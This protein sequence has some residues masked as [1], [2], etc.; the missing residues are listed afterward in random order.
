MILPIFAFAN[1]GVSLI[2]LSMESLFSPMTLGIALGLFVGKQVGVFGICWL[3]IKTGLAKIPEG[4]NWTQL[5]GVSLLCGIGFTMSLFIG[6]LAFE[7]QGLAYQ[8]SVKAG[9]LI[10][11]IMSA[12]LGGFVISRT[13]SHKTSDEVKNDKVSN[14][15]Y[16]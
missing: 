10:G 6:S 5:Y 13:T 2:G 8:A 9:V 12:L 3:A 14:V 4:S 1:A 15:N 11:S 7:E 16:S